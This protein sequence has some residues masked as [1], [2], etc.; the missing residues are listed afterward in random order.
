MHEMHTHGH[1]MRRKIGDLMQRLKIFGI[2]CDV[3]G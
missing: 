3:A 2:S 1:Y